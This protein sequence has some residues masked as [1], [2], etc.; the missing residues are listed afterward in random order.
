M[1]VFGQEVVEIEKERTVFDV[2]VKYWDEQ[3]FEVE[4]EP[5]LRSAESN[6]LICFSVCGV[7]AKLTPAG[8]HLLAL[9]FEPSQPAA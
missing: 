3:L 2:L 8:R 6:G 7:K 9:G 1:K 4:D 5:T